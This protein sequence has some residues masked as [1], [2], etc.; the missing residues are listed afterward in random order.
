MLYLPNPPPKLKNATELS[1][2]LGVHYSYF[3]K[4]LNQL[5]KDGIIKKFRKSYDLSAVLQYFYTAPLPPIRAFLSEGLLTV[6]EAFRIL[7]DSEDYAGMHQR[8]FE[9]RVQQGII[10]SLKIGS[11]YRISKSVLSKMISN[12]EIPY[13]PK[14][15]RAT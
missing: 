11:T 12:N 6:K 14:Q 7:Q 3:S 9:R 4:L 2:L 13:R 15:S 10:P 8:T 5:T 1:R